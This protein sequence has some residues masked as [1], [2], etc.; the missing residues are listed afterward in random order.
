MGSIPTYAFCCC[1]YCCY[2]SQEPTALRDPFF[3]EKLPRSKLKDLTWFA[4]VFRWNLRKIQSLKGSLPKD[5]RLEASLLNPKTEH[6]RY[7][8]WTWCSK[9]SLLILVF[10]FSFPAMAEM[11]LRM[12]EKTVWFQDGHSSDQPGN[13]LAQFV[14][15]GVVACS[16]I[17]KLGSH[18]KMLVMSICCNS[19]RIACSEILLYTYSTAWLYTW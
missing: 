10:L 15:M 18:V 1:Y 2:I 5:T 9:V 13:S 16:L 19:K 12:S 4:C 6:I 3:T 7:V 8:C 14:C 17:S 11:S